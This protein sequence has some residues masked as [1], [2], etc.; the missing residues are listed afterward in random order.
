MRGNRRSGRSRLVTVVSLGLL[1]I[2]ALPAYG[3]VKRIVVDRKVSPAFEGRAFGPA[4]P[5]ETLAGRAFGEL[6]PADPHNRIITDIQ[7]APRNAAGKVEYVA[8]FFLVKPIDMSRSSRLLWHDVPN[9]GGRITIAE[10]ERV[11]GDIG[12]SSGWQGDNAGATAPRENN[13]YATV[14]IARNADGSP[15]TGPV[16]GRIVNASGPDSRPLLIQGN[17]VPYKPASLDTTTATLETHASESID[18]EVSGVRPVASGD[19]AWARC[20]AS[21]PFPGTPDPT[22]ICVKGGFDPALLYQVVFTAQDPYVLGIGYA[23][24]RDVASFFRHAK[25]DEQ[26]TPNPIA[27]SVSWIISRGRSQSGNFLRA[28]LHLG[29]NQDEANRQVHD[30]MWPI[31]AGSRLTLNTRFALPDGALMLYE[32]RGEG[33]QWWTKWPDPVRGLP[34][35]SLLDRCTAT[36]TCP[37]IIEHFGAAEMWGLGLS[38]S[39]VGTSADRDIPLPANVRRYYIPSTPHGGGAGGFTVTPANGPQCPGANFGRGMFAANPV[40]HN[41]T[42]SALRVHFRNWVMKGTPPPASRYPTLAGGTL[43]D[44]TREALG[45]PDIPG[46]PA[47]AP[48]GFINAVLDYDWGPDFNYADGSGVPSK[49]PP[50]I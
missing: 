47:G 41:E 27:G 6:D 30:G 22:Q 4:G 33:A 38:P 26:G 28:F 44:P 10:S 50:S 3:E 43:V 46:V 11:F 25:Q 12:L 49:I 34:E 24:F 29:F 15:V 37:K 31:I 9:R 2:S 20:S 16:L 36:R 19:W 42:V 1:W 35:A 21:N 5:Y 7:L 32:A 13:D 40:S 48:G 17:P 8:T 23:A 18:G 45:F 14:P 39:F